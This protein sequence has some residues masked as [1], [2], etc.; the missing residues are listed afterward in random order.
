MNP[1]MLLAFFVKFIKNG[2]I[3]NGC[4]DLVLE[5][6][7]P[8]IEEQIHRFLRLSMRIHKI[9]EANNGPMSTGTMK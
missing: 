1:E 9:L 3:I 8:G 4:L 7:A 6:R 2:K 5:K